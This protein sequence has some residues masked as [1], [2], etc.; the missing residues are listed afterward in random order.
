MTQN[1]SAHQEIEEVLQKYGKGVHHGDGASLKEAFH[2][3]ATIGGYYKGHLILDTRD[4]FVK[5]IE[6]MP[7]PATQGE[8]YDKQTTSIEV[9]GN[10]ATASM[11]ERYQGLIFTNYFNL[12]KLNGH[13]SIINKTFSHEPR[14]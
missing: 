8:P 4:D 13:W 6:S 3:Q 7:I 14:R 12:L 10:A 5:S 2:P 11:R 1:D 9:A